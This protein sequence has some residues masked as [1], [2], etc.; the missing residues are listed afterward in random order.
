MKEKFN[1]NFLPNF[2]LTDN[3]DALIGSCKDVF[4]HPYV[5]ITC[6]FHL[7]KR[8][9]EKLRKTE[10][11]PFKGLI[12]IGIKALKN[13]PNIQFFKHV[14]QML[15]NLWK[16]NNVP[17]KLINTFESEYI[18]KNFHWYYKCAFP[19]KSLSNNSLESGNNV[20]KQFMNRKAHNLKEFLIKMK[21]FLI[22]YSS[23]EK[24]TFQIHASVPPKIKAVAEMF[25]KEKKYYSTSS[26]PHKLFFLRKRIEF[27]NDELLKESLELHAKKEKVIDTMEEYFNLYSK[28]RMV[29]IL[30]QQCDC[31][32]FAKYSYCKH[33]IASK[34]LSG[35]LKEPEVKKKGKPGRKPYI[36]KALIK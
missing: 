3:S 31:G 13:S 24:T 2:I 30:T 33:L 23:K 20:V 34:I 35:E 5:H 17:E 14:W 7:M 10:N 18:N 21:E 36:K 16:L 25:V 12:K 6:H 22:V 15:K 32:N 27:G 4:S 9:N 28:F 11:K 1:Y 26:E 8:L 19:G 29:N